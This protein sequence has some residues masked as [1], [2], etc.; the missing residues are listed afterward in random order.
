MR[1]NLCAQGVRGLERSS[2]SR[3]LAGSLAIWPAYGRLRTPHTCAQRTLLTADFID[4]Q[5]NQLV[6]RTTVTITSLVRE[7]Q[8]TSRQ[9][10]CANMFFAGIAATGYNHTPGNS[11][12]HVA[13]I[14]DFNLSGA[15]A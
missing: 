11:T 9:H 4:R 13:R 6:R 14:A 2:P 15:L 7:E 1:A 8:V 3:P 5:Q 10:A 12:L